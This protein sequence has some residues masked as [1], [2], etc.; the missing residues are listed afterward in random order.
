MA[1]L[2]LNRT[3]SQVVTVMLFTHVPATDQ[4]LVT[5]TTCTYPTTLQATEIPTPPVIALSL[6]PM[7]ILGVLSAIIM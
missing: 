5:G 2:L 7:D 4:R 6:H 3:S 1:M